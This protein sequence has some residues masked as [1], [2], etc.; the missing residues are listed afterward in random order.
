MYK[1]LTLSNNLRVILTPVK[2]AYSASASIFVKAGSRFENAKNNGIAHFLEH[3]AF[4]GSEKYPTSLEFSKQIESL[5]GYMNA[6]TSSELISYYMRASS[7]HTLEL[8]DLLD[9]LLFHALY[10]DK[11]IEK[12]KG[13]VTE[14]LNMYNDVPEQ[15]VSILVDGLVW[16]NHPLGRNPVG[17]KETIKSFTRADFID[18][19]TSLYAPGSMIIGISGNFDEGAVAKELEAKFGML[20][21][22]SVSTFEPFAQTQE[23]PRYAIEPKKSEQ[24]H[25]C[26]NFP[27]VSRKDARRQQ[28]H[29]LGMILGG[30]FSSRLFET[31]R[32]QLGLA[33][34][35]DAST[36]ELMDT[37]VFQIRAGLNNENAVKGV[38]EIAKQ[39]RLL[40]DEGVAA[41][42]LNRQKEHMKGLL[43]LSLEDHQKQN[44]FIVKQE[45]LDN[46]VMGYEEV[47]AQIEAVT[48]GQ[49]QDLAN[50][51]LTNT[52]LNLA[53]VGNVEEAKIKE[54]AQI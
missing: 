33:Y 35:V 47:V 11:A 29:M 15:L 51:F 1:K 3:M 20:K 37:G 50:E 17:T 48:S 25:I 10:T 5:G 12:E 7:T 13:V 27:G 53:V 4:Q 41:D 16:P 28:M 30:G 46:E 19:Q 49:V 6:Y 18:Y 24:T 52:R 31:I 8:L 22:K 38:G 42:E 43:A 36:H 21:D 26:M 9:Q 23:A 44:H 39:I 14:E 54:A 45:L 32:N 34:Y 40:Q 2:D